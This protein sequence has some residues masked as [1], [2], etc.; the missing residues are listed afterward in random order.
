MS[1]SLDVPSLEALPILI[2][3]IALR[4]F[5]FLLPVSR[6]TILC[7]NIGIVG[8]RSGHSG[9]RDQSTVGSFGGHAGST[10]SFFE[11]A[12]HV[13][14]TR[15]RKSLGHAV[16]IISGRSTETR[17]RVKHIM[18]KN[19]DLPPFRASKGSRVRSGSIRARTGSFTLTIKVVSS[20]CTDS[21][22]KYLVFSIGIFSYLTFLTDSFKTLEVWS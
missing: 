13:V 11:H 19:E 2:H 10:T 14:R 12:L 7:I 5:I 17:W 8:T 15:A 22:G 20:G 21:I 4:K 3:I 6:S 16:K 9:G 18:N 1:F